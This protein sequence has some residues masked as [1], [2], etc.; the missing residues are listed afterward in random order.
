MDVFIVLQNVVDPPLLHKKYPSVAE[1]KAQIAATHDG[2]LPLEPYQLISQ[3]TLEPL[4]KA[5][6]ETLPSVSGALRPRIAVVHAG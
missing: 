1:L 5:V 6:A 2:T 3:Y 4:L